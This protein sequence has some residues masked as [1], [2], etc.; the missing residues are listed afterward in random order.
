MPAT[1]QENTFEPTLIARGGLKC[2]QIN[3]H[4]A[5]TATTSLEQWMADKKMD[6]GLLQEPY[7]RRNKVSGF[8][9]YNVF[10]GTSFGKIRAAII[11]KK[12]I[13]VMLLNQYSD[14][15]QVAISIKLNDKT[16]IFASVYMPFDSIDPPPS[17]LLKNL[18][19][20]CKLKKYEFLI[21]CDANSHHTSWGSSND[22]IRGESLLGYCL[23]KEL[24]ILNK[25]CRPTFQNAIRKEVLDLTISSHRLSE[26]IV[27][28]E[29]S[30]VESFSDH[31][32]ITFRVCEE[33]VLNNK[34][35]RN[36]CKTNWDQYNAELR[37]I[38]VNF[39]G[40]D[41]L[42]IKAQKLEHCIITAFEKSCKL[43]KG[44]TGKS[45]L[46]WNQNLEK[47]KKEV[48]KLK[49]RADRS[50]IP[51]TL[52]SYRQAKREY[53][54]EIKSA[55]SKSWQK[56]CTEMS[57]LNQTARVQKILKL[58]KREEIGSLKDNQGNYTTTPK[59]TLQVLL[60]KHFP[61][62]E[63]IA[64]EPDIDTDT[65]INNFDV[66]Q[67]I[68]EESVRSAI[69]SFKPYKSPGLDGI[70]PVLLQKGID[71]LVTYIVDIY[72]DSILQ[73]KSPSRWLETKVVFIPKPGKLSYDSADKFRPISLFSFLLKGV[74]RIVQWHLDKF[75]LRDKLHKN[76]Y[77]Y[78][79]ST[80]C[81]DALHNLLHKIEK[82]LEQKKNALVLFLDL[83]A[84]FST[85][86]VEGIIKNLKNM[87]CDAKILTW[88]KDLLEHRVVIAFLMGDQVIK[89]VVRG[90]PQGGI[91]SVTFW[92]VGSQ[93]M[94]ERFPTPTIETPSPTDTN[95]FADDSATITVGENTKIMAKRIQEAANT[96]EQW[97]TDN[98]LR[99]NAS[100]CKLMLFTRKRAQ[101]KYPVYINGEEVEYVKEYKYLGVTFSDNLSWK[102]HMSNIAKRATITFL[103]CRTMLGRTWGLSPKISRW[104]YIALVRPIIS[105]ASIIWIKGIT[106]NGHLH[107]L[108]KVQR[109]A[110]LSILNA[111]PSTPTAGMEVILNMEPMS[112]FLRTQ[113]LNTY[114]R[115]V[116]N[117]NW[118]AQPGEYLVSKTSHTNLILSVAQQI[119]S[120]H[121]PTD[122][123][124][125]RELIPTKFTTNILSREYMHMTIRKPKPAEADTINCFT[126]GSR[127]EEN[128][129]F[130]YIIKGENIHL[131]GF[132]YLGPQ[133]TVYQS[134]I[135][136]IIEATH[137]ILEAPT[138]PENMNINF[139]IDN[140]AAI[141]SL[142][143]YQVKNTQVLE[144]KLILNRL[145]E[146]NNVQLFWIPGHS[147]HWG[148]EVA[149]KLAKRGVKLKL[150][151]PQ[152]IIP[153]SNTAVKADV[154]KWGAEKHQQA[155]SNRLDCR[156][157]K[158]MIPTIKR[159][160][161]GQIN[162]LS[163][164]NV[165]RITQML[166]GHC[167]L[168]RHL[169][170]M[171]MEDD[172]TC[173]NCL[174]DEETT[175]H[176]LTECPAFARE[177][178]NTL[179]KM[180]LRQT[181]LKHLK[182]KQILNFIKET[183][184]L[185]F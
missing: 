82:A 163:R 92:N 78:R 54:L 91:L 143:K 13:N 29:V 71:F 69:D 96:M 35:F 185:D 141:Q 57:D 103:Q 81:E 158:M 176:F 169:F 89:V 68:T 31:N 5:I 22:N 58:G 156:Q 2:T 114:L 19:D 43:S 180:F 175:E 102:T 144:G 61:G 125:Y 100:K 147:G 64:N 159:S 67:A 124:L 17:I 112:I 52:E 133:A 88:C 18:V 70:Y 154:R 150:H 74:E 11:T 14:S 174:E 48:F 145:A 153:I 97:A 56:F 28:W 87:G 118:K 75:T 55:K 173:E 120:I 62:K 184:R 104:A 73:G 167:T 149:D 7:L 107:L 110:C 148:N 27:D 132:S 53:K 166:T 41:S 140:Q 106:V 115:L 117:G 8:K 24:F 20:F 155:W 26:V 128:S 113:S 49:R 90:T 36:V 46:Y 59:E 6:L 32:Y 94:L 77:A 119:P 131:Q 12:S 65:G 9:D 151:G 121:M 134:E 139:Y 30:M 44:K 152:P 93:N 33:V 86:T 160:T 101:I 95:S 178:Y 123:M 170:L 51:E 3:L 76:I 109:R 137:S 16:V 165:K 183:K 50:D 60:D 84:A 138:V 157:T 108:E 136:A 122:K 47:L 172:P 146:N 130:G 63:D 127:F 168:Q 161:W 182:I 79:E 25:G 23:S 83:T 4:H 37:K 10:R 39:Q 1:N 181:D 45:P 80:S 162:K 42:D 177:R 99:F 66:Y 164:K 171:K 40:N 34:D 135:H 98:G 111:M 38:G 129:G 85:M 179:G 21:S 15:D 105:Y 126:D 72:R 142:G 116:A